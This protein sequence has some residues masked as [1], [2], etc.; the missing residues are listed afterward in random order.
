MG[1]DKIDIKKL[2][3]IR[4]C[5]R[6]ISIN[7]YKNTEWH[8]RELDV[9]SKTGLRNYLNTIEFVMG[10]RY[11]KRG[12]KGACPT[13]DIY[14]GEKGDNPLHEIFSYQSFTNKMIRRYFLVLFKLAE[15]PMPAN[16]LVLEIQAIEDRDDTEENSGH[17]QIRQTLKGLESKGIIRPGNAKKY[18]LCKT[19]DLE[20][21]L[22]G[23]GL[24]LLYFF[25]AVAPFSV[26]GHYIIQKLR[27]DG[28]L[29]KK[30]PQLLYRYLF[31]PQCLD[32]EIMQLVSEA[33]KSKKQLHV[34]LYKTRKSQTEETEFDCEPLRIFVSRASGREY[35]VYRKQG[36]SSL[37]SVRLDN[38]KTLKIRREPS[39]LQN[40]AQFWC[41][42]FDKNCADE[43]VRC[44]VS[45][46]DDP[47]N[48]RLQQ[49]QAERRYGSVSVT[50][51]EAQFEVMTNDVRN[52]L[53]CLKKYI[54][55]ITA[56]DCDA[57]EKKRFAEDIDK[58]LALYEDVAL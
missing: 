8:M 14:T 24:S 52:T 4:T 57:D 35:M 31:F 29:K 47:D 53:F 13:V 49:L 42:P 36:A 15:R 21:L 6:D 50:G 11:D 38:I 22:G 34:V 58:T 23:S 39:T 40:D 27:A 44:V 18:C 1:H 51:E 19:D 37:R 33:L 41:A 12:G 55:S 28:T 43:K 25:T 45:L 7:G 56:L 10:D 16:Q 26:V 3:K 2:N 17:S 46:R 20:Q 32:V 5:L 54:G 9:N 48:R 30:E